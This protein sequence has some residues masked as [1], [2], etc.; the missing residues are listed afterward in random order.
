ML[1]KVSIIVP[2]YNVEKYLDRCIQSLLK[3]TLQ[4]IE[5]I[6]VDDESPDSCPQMCDKYAIYDSR[7]KV[8]HKKN[9][10]LGMACNSGLKIATGDYI[11]FCDS[12]DWVSPATYE[13]LYSTAINTNADAV[14][15]GIQT[16]ND[17]GIV[18]LMNQPTNFEIITERCRIYEF[19]MDMISS[20]AEDPIESHI[21]MSAKIV[22]YRRNLIEQYNLKFESERKLISEDLIWNLDI[23]G[24][25]SIITTIP[26]TFYYY[27]NNA[28]SISKKIRLDRFGYFKIIRNE[29]FHRTANMGFPID[30]K[31]RINRMFLRYV[32]HDIGN[33]LLSENPF[34]LR[35]KLVKERMSDKTTQIVLSSFPLKKLTKRQQFVMWAIRYQQVILIYLLFKLFRK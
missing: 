22:L 23:L 35:Y 5:I 21:A 6:L 3:Q 30:V 34:L 27:Y 24:H 14:Y 7:I 33:I 9:E 25:A 20:R 13:T 28:N 12:D 4:E 32:R 17:E 31:E 1:P 29:L 8:I 10:G 18:T 19:A 16:I 26:Q 2:V 11:A 15:S